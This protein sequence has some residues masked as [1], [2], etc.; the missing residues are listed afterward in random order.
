[1]F[2]SLPPPPRRYV[3]ADLDLGDLAALGACHDELAT[4]PLVADDPWALEQWLR[5]WSELESLM[6]EEQ[7]RREIAVTCHTEDPAIEATYLDWVDRVAPHVKPLRDRLARRLVAHPGAGALAPGGHRCLLRGLANQVDL[8]RDA[9]VPLEA[10]QQ[11]LCAEHQK[12]RG[13]MKAEFDGAPRTLEAI[14]AAEDHDDPTRREA[15]WRAVSGRFLADKPALDDLFDRLLANRLAQTHAAGFPD[16]RA[17]R[18]RQLARFDYGPADCLAFHAAIE[19]AVVPLACELLAARAHELGR[20]ALRPWDLQ[21]P[22]VGQSALRPFA[23]A[24]A[25]IAGAAAVF[26]A[27]DPGFGQ[28][29][30]DLAQRG[31]LDLMSRPGKA[32]GG[33]Q[34]SLEASGLPFIFAN[35][36]GRHDDVLTLLHEGGHAFHALASAADPLIWNRSPP[37]EFCEVASMSMEL[38]ASRH[39]GAFYTPA[40]LRQAT[41]QQLEAIVLFLPYMACVDAF[42]HWLYTHPD[43]ARHPPTRDATWLALHRRFFPGVD[44]SDLEAERAA[45]WQR[46][47]HIFELPFYYIEYGIAQLGALQLFAGYLRDPEATVAAYRR[48]LALGGRAG[49]RDLFSATGLRFDLGEATLHDLMD[50]VRTTLMSCR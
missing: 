5:D 49:L 38:M 11:R 43:Q 21:A 12:L 2:G 47:L 36:V 1:M 9:L 17:Y 13:A 27:V 30:A 14:E 23:D 25:L 7:T 3:P 44:W 6:H 15:A 32:P 10:E 31:L 20:P 42:Q 22:R 45:L 37:M 18:F 26:T 4:R 39:L 50:L 16:Y 46:K 34:A 35:A 29:F 48:G 40:E 19:A 24:D 8:Y 41:C 33:Y 28:Q